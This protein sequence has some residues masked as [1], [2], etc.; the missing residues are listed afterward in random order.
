MTWNKLRQISKKNIFAVK[1]DRF[2]SKSLRSFCRRI[3]ASLALFFFIASFFT[4]FNFYLAYS[5]GFF[6]L[7]IFIYLIF[8][9]IEFFYNSMKNEGISFRIKESIFDDSF[10]LDYSLVKVLY[11]LD[12]IDVSASSLNSKIGRAILIRSGIEQK[13]FE[14]FVN[15][16]RIPVIATSL[17]FPEES[18]SLVNFFAAVYD[19]DTRLAS[20]LN[21]R[22]VNRDE[23][24][25][26]VRWVS[27]IEEKKRRTERFWSR[28]KLGAI[29]SIGTSWSYGVSR[30]I[31]AFGLKINTGTNLSSID[32]DN[33]F[34]DKELDL[35]E[36]ILERKEG[37]NVLIIE[38]D[39]T[40]SRDL[41]F[42]LQKRINLGV[43]LPSLEH[44]E[45]IELDTLSILATFKDKGEFETELIKILNESAFSGNVIL[46]IKDLA[47]FIANCR[48][49]GVNIPSIFSDFLASPNIHI[50]AHTTNPDFHY[51]IES[52]SSLLQSFERL[53]PDPVG[54]DASLP[55][56]MEK[57]L[58]LESRYK[59][60]IIFTFP[61][62][63][64]I[65]ESSD[66]YITYGDMPE[67]AIN[68]MEDIVRFALGKT[69]FIRESDV[70][71]FMSE[72]TGIPI[73]PMKQDEADK[74]LNLEETLHKRLVGQEEAISAISSSI[75]RSRSGIVSHKKPIASFLFLGPTG[76][77]KTET[78]KALAENFFGDEEKILRLDMSEYN[79][80]EAMQ[81]LIGNFIENKS[82]LLASNIKDNPYGVLLLDEFEKSAKDVHDLF[83]QILDEGFFTDALG[84]KINCRNLIIIATSNAGGLHI[85]K[86]MED[87]KNIESEKKNIIDSIISEKIFKPELLNRF[88]GIILFHPLNIKELKD[89]TELELQKLQKRLKGDG[90]DFLINDST[91]SFLVEKAS[92]SEFGARKI[93]R[94]IK[95][96]VEDRIAKQ[97]LSGEVKPGGKI[98]LNLK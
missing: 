70:S 29:P 19:A 14:N 23:F 30:E 22:F 13:D 11:S 91:I 72:R 39:E 67:K 54:V 74:I 25:G 35:I 47:G 92:N 68:I 42:R 32:I 43:S 85:W 6:F 97:I 66:R 61:S 41:I 80:P 34:R 31:S 60:K 12:E 10:Y 40:I 36:N 94:L 49:I 88:D 44:K 48:A 2:L 57:A 71:E 62:L 89:I 53:V 83:L 64:V 4:P 38:N 73:G 84:E 69:Y 98:E 82:G 63:R 55:V 17:K 78:C 8:S 28:D 96:E 81:R 87:G 95:S 56:I 33:G 18:P 37:A 77:G 27:E 46:Y 21:S 50:I 9:F 79:G 1:I 15:G 58:S 24:L 52:N 93:N 16:E 59:Y 20:F 26:A 86:A 76:V 3:S 90:Y 7:F 45:I 65:A 5:D 75:R 51:F